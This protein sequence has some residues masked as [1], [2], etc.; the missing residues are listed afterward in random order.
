[1]KNRPRK[2]IKGT[3][4]PNEAI[5]WWLTEHKLSQEWLARIMERPSKTLSE[6]M[7][8]KAR[9]TAKTALELE[10]VTGINAAFFL[11]LQANFDLD[12]INNEK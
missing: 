12:S 5:H 10:H 7:T 3:R 9:V 2:T 8:N 11:K 1:M 6:I 4:Y